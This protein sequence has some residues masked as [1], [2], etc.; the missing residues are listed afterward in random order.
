MDAWRPKVGD[1]G[2]EQGSEIT[3]HF[4]PMLGK[5]IIWGRDRIEAVNRMERA[6][7]NYRIK[8]IK[9]CIPFELAV[10]Q[11]HD[12]RY[13]YFDTS[14]IENAF[15]FAAL[16]RMKEESEEFIAAIA[17]FGFQK[18]QNDEIRQSFEPKI[19]KWKERQLLLMRMV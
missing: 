4:D 17:A 15:D 13:G 3:I 7:M 5:L 8:G 1:S 11:H 16:D 14:F 12:F 18:M 9:T 10:M 2:V 19:N 6:L